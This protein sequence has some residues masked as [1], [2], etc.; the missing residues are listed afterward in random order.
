MADEP[1]LKLNLVDVYGN[2]LNEKV[3]IIIRHQEFSETVKVSKLVK[4]WIQIAGLRGFPQGRYKIEIDPPSYRCVSHFL[5][6][7]AT[8]VTNREIKFPIELKKIVSIKF[9]DFAELS[10]EL[11][12]LLEN[13]GNVKGFEGLNGK[14]LYDAIGKDDIRRAGFLNIAAKTQRTVL[15]NGKTVFSAISE[16]LDIRGDRFFAIVP[17]Q[18][19]DDTK[20]SIADDIFEKAPSILHHPPK[21]YDHAGSYKT[22]DRYG[23]LQLTFFAGV[24]NW[25]ADIDIDDAAGIEHIFQ[26]IRNAMPDQ[27]TH[28]YD[29]HQILI[30]YQQIDPGYSFEV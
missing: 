17:Q 13:S 23:N 10:G 18:L 2:S 6:I 15:T 20:N 21:D 5:N 11:K 28:P 22:K 16:L 19:R 9:P 25:V 1:L 12:T 24:E 30:G 26:V 3:D 14:N 8:G 7:K 29:I 4:G 27:S